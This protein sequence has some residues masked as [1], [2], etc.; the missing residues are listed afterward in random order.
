M[1]FLTV[2]LS[3]LGSITTSAS[4]M[5]NDSIRTIML[6]S[7]VVTGR[8]PQVSENGGTTKIMVEKTVLARMGGADIM[9]AHTPGLHFEN[10]EIVVNGM[11][12]PVFVVD[13]RVLTD[14]SVLSVIQAN[15]IKYIE[16]DK[17]PSAKYSPDGRPVIRITS[18]KKINDFVF[19]NIGNYNKQTRMFSE[20]PLLNARVK[21]KK[22]SMSLNFLGGSEGSKNKETY[23]RDIF[24]ET[25][26][27]NIKMY[28]E[29]PVRILA[30]RLN[31]ALDYNVNDYNRIGFYYFFLHNKTKNNLIGSDL[32]GY[33]NDLESKDI[34]RRG[35]ERG[36][37]HNISAQYVYKKEKRSLN[38][39]QDVLFKSVNQESSTNEV[40]NTY[41]DSYMSNSTTDYVSS[42]TTANYNC[43]LPWEIK[44][45]F[46][47]KFNFLKS[48]SEIRSD[49][50]FI[51]GGLYNNKINLIERSPQATV[52]LSRSFGNFVINPTLTYSYT[53]RR[54][55]NIQTD[56]NR[57]VQHYSTL[58][59]I[60]KVEYIPND[61]LSFTLSYNSYE[62]QPKFSQI[63]SG[64]SFSDSLTYSIGNPDIKP[65]HVNKTNFV[66][67][68]KDWSLSMSYTHRRDPIVS[69]ETLI[70]PQ[71]NIITTSS[72][73]FKSANDFRIQLDY[74]HTFSKLSVYAEGELSLPNG[75]FSFLGVTYKANKAAFNGQIN[76]SYSINE[77][78]SLFTDYTYQGFNV[79]LTKRQKPVNAW[80]MG[81]V[82][83][84]LKNRLEVYFA[85]KDILEKENYNNLYYCYDNIKYGTFGKNDMRGVE[86]RV[87][88]TLFNKNIKVKTI[89]KNSNIIDRL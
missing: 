23:F 85:V 62:T 9:L 45:I 65:T 35:I 58:F 33:D 6:D 37:L 66:A 44:A 46:N 49:A 67:S 52:S 86:L 15:N 39:T 34:S 89:N 48:T 21:F 71:S 82:A 8:V 56:N 77:N 69:V 80:N 27:F 84:L 60:V 31:F 51:M 24:R 54:V 10:G 4:N 78:I 87:A 53:Y 40:S 12:K 47:G 72:I 76:L 3:V 79:M 19:L 11:G 26:T 36:N 61:D 81:V 1:I 25:S 83:S 17:L 14:N 38:V 13:G 88:Y 43:I 64:L 55:T 20:V 29:N 74:S 63:N 22:V 50:S 75:E 41:E 28:R 32:S 68:W 70:E 30:Q 42:S 57:V 5:V 7:V 59:P 16:I 18:M 2:I 73:N